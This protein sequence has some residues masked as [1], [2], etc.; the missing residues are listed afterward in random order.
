MNT[1]MHLFQRYG[2]ELEYMIVDNDTLAI[3]PIT[4]DLIKSVLGAFSN[5][6][7]RGLVTWSNELVLHVLEL[8]CSKPELDLVALAEGFQ[9]NIRDINKKLMAFNARLM[10]TAAHPMMNPEKETFLWP[11]DN[12]EIYDIYNRIFNCKGH[13]WSNLQSTHLN[14]PFYDDEEFA[15][16]HAAVRLI[17]PILPAI[18]ASSPVLDGAATGYLDK[19]LDYYQSNQKV[20]PELT[21]K[22]I[23]ERAFSKRHYHKMIYEPIQAAV[24]PYDEQHILEP[25]WLNSRGA[26]ARFDRGSIE[27]R[28]LDI[29]EC[30]KADM[31]IVALIIGVLKV[32]AAEVTCSAHEQQTWLVAPLSKIFQQTIVTA[33]NTVIADA[34]YLQ[35]FGMTQEQATAKELWVHLLELVKVHHP[36]FI[37]PW[38]DTLHQIL[39]GGTLASRILTALDGIYTEDNIKLVYNE[40]ADCLSNNEIFESCVKEKL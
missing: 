33:E 19:R 5:E 27:I 25:V 39:E 37:G 38:L 1:R 36:V 24:A 15:R 16:L 9:Q 11:H 7:D 8:K 14:L 26:I 6:V 10:P 18:A 3:R 13:G 17:L 22:V 12:N 4:D 20:I 40:L 35:V 31:A 30:P 21:G 29:Q 28:L 23:P 34:A 32:L 2:I